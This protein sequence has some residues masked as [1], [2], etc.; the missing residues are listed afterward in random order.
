LCPELEVHCEGSKYTLLWLKADG[1]LLR[2]SRQ[3]SAVSS[4]PEWRHYFTDCG[5][6]RGK[7]KIPQALK[8]GV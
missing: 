6:F 5:A 7:T 2:N 3:L 1:Y 4:Q 8:L